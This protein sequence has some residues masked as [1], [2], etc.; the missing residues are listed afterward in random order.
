M[1]KALLLIIFYNISLIN[2]SS[3]DIDARH[4]NKG[5]IANSSKD[6]ITDEISHDAILISDKIDTENYSNKNIS[7]I[8][9]ACIENNPVVFFIGSTPLAILTE[10]VIEYRFDKNNG[11]QTQADD[12]NKLQSAAFKKEDKVNQFVKQAFGANNLIVRFTGA[13]GRTVVRFK[14]TNAKPAIDKALD[15]CGWY[16]P[17][18]AP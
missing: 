16:K 5:W 11:V 17:D 7:I 8:S 3:A 18:P 1:F 6:E 4:L 9:I 13:R 14:A 15:G 12:Y 10:S 2:V